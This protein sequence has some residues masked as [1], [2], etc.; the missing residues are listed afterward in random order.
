MPTNDKLKFRSGE[1][2]I[3]GPKVY[4]FILVLVKFLTP[5]ITLIFLFI[6]R[7]ELMHF[8]AELIKALFHSSG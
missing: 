4:V 8:G 1:D 6:E 7:K 3:E 5:I 2:N